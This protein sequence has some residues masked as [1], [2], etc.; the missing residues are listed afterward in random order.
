MC[1]MCLKKPTFWAAIFNFVCWSAENV[2]NPLHQFYHVDEIGQSVFPSCQK[3]H[4]CTLHFQICRLTRVSFCCGV[5]E[6]FIP[7]E[8]RGERRA[9]LLKCPLWMVITLNS[10]RSAS[11]SNVQIKQNWTP[12]GLNPQ[13]TNQLNFGNKSPDMC[14]NTLQRPA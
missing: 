11:A 6:V 14:S 9:N 8:V 1:T 12:V 10:V 7:P 2:T 5:P 4:A 13:M 3:K